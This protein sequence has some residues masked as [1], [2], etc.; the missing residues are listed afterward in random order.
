MKKCRLKWGMFSKI[1]AS[2]ILNYSLNI[3]CMKYEGALEIIFLLKE[4]MLITCGKR[5][6]AQSWLVQDDAMTFSRL[7]G[8]AFTN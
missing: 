2:K 1:E 4:G 5:T 7:E 6:V 8:I 3:D